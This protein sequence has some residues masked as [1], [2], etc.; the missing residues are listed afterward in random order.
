MRRISSELDIPIHVHCHNDFGMGTA[1]SLSALEAGAQCVDTSINGLGERSGLSALAEVVM[2]LV[3]IYKINNNSWKLEM[4]PELTNFINKICDSKSKSN[5]PI[6][7][8]N[9]FTHTAGI[10]SKAVLKNPETYE[11]FSP[12]IIN[13]GRKFVINKYSGI[14]I[15]KK[16]LIDLECYLTDQE[17]VRALSTVKSF[18]NKN[19]WSE[20][21]L[22]N[23][24]NDIKKNS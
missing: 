17:L 13:R 10:H 14:S 15:L 16:K 21:D 7:G 8:E 11:P 6:I 23:L 12:E 20:K 4:I 18:E 24:V 22:Y 2:A 5:Q 9:A 1:N 19:D 3:T